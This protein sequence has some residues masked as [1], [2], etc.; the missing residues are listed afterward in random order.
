LLYNVFNFAHLDCWTGLA[1][2]LERVSQRKR[3]CKYTIPY[4]LAFVIPSLTSWGNYFRQIFATA[5]HGSVPAVDSDC[6]P[7]AVKRLTSA[8]NLVQLYQ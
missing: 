5:S 4:G 6:P 3:L 7:G 1:G 8:D 2:S